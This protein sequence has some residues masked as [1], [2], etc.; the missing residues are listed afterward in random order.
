PHKESSR[1]SQLAASRPYVAD[2]T[3]V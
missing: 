3:L 2:K 1:K